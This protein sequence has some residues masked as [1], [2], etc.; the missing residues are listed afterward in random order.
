MSKDP[1]DKIPPK[2]S[3]DDYVKHR[4]NQLDI[5]AKELDYNYAAPPANHFNEVVKRAYDQQNKQLEKWP[6][7]SSRSNRLMKEQQEARQRAL[8]KLEKMQKAAADRASGAK[9][10]SDEELK[11]MYLDILTEDAAGEARGRILRQLQERVRDLEKAL[12]DAGSKDPLLVATNEVLG[13]ENRRLTGEVERLMDECAVL[14]RKLDE[15]HDRLYK[16]ID[17]LQERASGRTQG[18]PQEEAGQENHLRQSGGEQPTAR[19][20]EY[21]AAGGQ[22]EAAEE[23]E[24]ARGENSR[25]LTVIGGTRS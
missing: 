20:G 3:L 14:R 9:Q 21:N 11:E 7:N 10:W 4:M 1:K 8:E 18:V 6:S 19:G 16:T 13:D 17:I 23:G 15:A 24:G 22:R 5:A 12:K 25:S 2:E